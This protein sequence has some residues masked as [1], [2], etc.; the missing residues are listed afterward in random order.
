[1]LRE[2]LDYLKDKKIYIVGLS[3]AEGSAVAS[4]LIKYSFDKNT[5]A[6]DFVLKKDFKESFNWFH[7]YLSDK[8][9][10]D[11]LKS[12]QSSSIKVYYKNDYLK[13]VEKADIIFASQGWIKHRSNYPKL[14]NI[15]NRYP[16]K[17]L[18]MTKLYLELSQAKIIGITGTNG[19]S[20]TARLVYEICRNTSKKTYFAGNDRANIQ[21]LDKI[22][23]M[24]LKDFLVLEIS[25]RQLIAPITKSPHIAVILNI[26]PNHLDDYK[27]FKKY[28]EVKSRILR[29]QNK[30][31][32]AVLNFDNKVTKNLAKKTKAKVYFFSRK[33]KLRNGAFLEGD[34]IIV[35]ISSKKEIITTRDKIKI[36]GEHNIENILAA[37]LV[38][39]LAGVSKSSIK[40][41]VENFQGLKQRLEYVR[42][43][44][45]R[46]FYYDRQGTTPDATMTSVNTFKDNVILITG[47][48]DKG[49]NYKNLADTISKRVKYAIILPGTGSNKILK[50]LKKKK[51]RNYI[52]VKNVKEA[53]NKSFRISQR[54]D[55]IILSPSCAFADLEYVGKK[56]QTYYDFVKN[57]QPKADPPLAEKLNNY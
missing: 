12:M 35:K 42:I 9:K 44:K 3:G 7:K 51:F 26:T 6:T 18:S 50:E 16:E 41:A 24:G 27:T 2:F 46:K 52:R 43:L 17:F 31:D 13:D 38:G 10:K 49:M 56:K 37:S 22:E 29:Y 36:P 34:K 21:V 54:G 55:T 32:F 28:V 1:M 40:K 39:R 4:F 11:I 23:K 57:L 5:E 48:E 8:A 15:F 19:K 47:G 45:G 25:D 20:T 30:N 14:K 53:V 33:S